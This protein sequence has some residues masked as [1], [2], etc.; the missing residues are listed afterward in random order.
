MSVA[1]KLF[2]RS[3]VENLESMFRSLYRS[4]KTAGT[5]LKEPNPQK[6]QQA[7]SRGAQASANWMLGDAHASRISSSSDVL[8][9]IN[10][11]SQSLGRIPGDIEAALAQ[12]LKENWF[13]S[14][15]ALALMSDEEAALLGI[16]IRLRSAIS[17]L[18][19]PGTQS[20]QIVNLAPFRVPAGIEAV[21]L[22]DVYSEQDMNRPIEERQCP[23]HNRFGF[24]WVKDKPKVSNRSRPQKYALSL[25][26][27]TP[28]LK[29]ELE[30]LHTFLTTRFFGQQ[31]EPIAPVTAKKYEDHARAFLGY[32]HKEVGIEMENLSLVCTV[33]SSQRNA[34]EVMFEY[35]E[36]LK[37]TRNIGV[38]TEGLVIRSTAAIAKYL[39][40]KESSVE[41]SSGEKAY[42]DLPVMKELRRMSNDSKKAERTAER[43]S[44]E[45]AK[46]I[47]WPKYLW[48]VDELHKECGGID[49]MSQKPRALKDIAWSLQ[50]YLLFAVLSCV[51]DRQRTLRELTLGK[52]LVKDVLSGRWV[53]KHTSKD[54]KTGKAYGERPPLVIA[55]RIYPELEAYIST[56]RQHL[57]PKHDFLF[58]QANGEPFSDKN[59]YKVFWT[60]SYRL[61]GKKLNP[62][63]VR[64]SIV[65][66]LRAGNATE[67]ELESL[68]L[69]MGHSIEMQKKSYDRRTLKQ[70]VEPAVELLENLSR[71]TRS[72]SQ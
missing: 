42:S 4:S 16:P 57:H 29:V 15:E 62:H 8:T 44:D 48:M 43:C 31:V 50:K 28:S 34:V 71:V 70:K 59:L 51:P 41:R 30:G 47:E 1:I 39:Y 6:F 11:A 25:T 14:A 19:E 45:V 13:E 65:T 22:N 68:A 66:Y 37:R 35:L 40:H 67:S 69:Y 54:Y 58:T 20:T 17:D 26:E 49:K 32:L 36:W 72:Q 60:T 56:W 61:T 27:L 46:W 24:N 38:R 12:K 9:A 2:K 33:P 18:I 63:L 53:I 52:T 55:P 3:L 5:A 64:D 10:V 23:P 7:G 21:E